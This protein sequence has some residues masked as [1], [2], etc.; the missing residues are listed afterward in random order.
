MPSVIAFFPWLDAREAMRVG[1]VRLIPYVQRKAPGNQPSMTQRDIDGV[2]RAYSRRPSSRERHA[3]I[4][5]VGRW[6]MG[7]NASP[8]IVSRLFHVRELIAFAALAKRRLFTHLDYTNSHTYALVVQRFEPGHAG[9][10]AFT[11]RRRDGGTNQLWGS[12][13]FAFHIPIHVRADA[14]MWLDRDLLAA[15]LKLPPSMSHIIE[16]ILEFNAANTDDFNVPEHVEMVMIKSAFE[17]LLGINENAKEFQR[18][19]ADTL[20][21]LRPTRPPSGP[22][23][24]R[25]RKRLPN[26]RAIEAWA[27]DF[28]VVRGMS[29]HGRQRATRGA[30]ILPAISHL[31]FAALLFPLLVKKTLADAGRFKMDD[32]D[33]ERLRAIDHYLMHNPFA[34][35]NRRDNHPWSEVET[36]TIIAASAAKF[37]PTMLK[38]LEK[39]AAQGATGEN[40]NAR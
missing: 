2:L 10:F 13:E 6:R 19:L 7:M 36:N 23:A 27:R 28:C 31:A 14:T 33:A 18:A 32:R 22:L 3:T 17:W 34:K 25:W 20:R 16:A 29:A 39:P 1:P 35:R 11:T 21:N 5:E 15:L 12:D 4:L 37:Y 38:A 26:A 40:P 8:L 24:R 9:T 30:S